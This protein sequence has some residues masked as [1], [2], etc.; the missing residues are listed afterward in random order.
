MSQARGPCSRFPRALALLATGLVLG[1]SGLAQAQCTASDDLRS[2]SASIAAS[3]RCER[4]RLTD[5]AFP[6]APLAMPACAGDV[7]DDLGSLAGVGAVF[8]GGDA[9][10]LAP[11]LRCQRRLLRAVGRYAQRSEERRVG[12]EGRS[13]WSPYH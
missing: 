13:R 7:V 6:C 10:S 4:V 12:K 9:S 8:A 5:P 2:L 1:G 11:Q 3:F